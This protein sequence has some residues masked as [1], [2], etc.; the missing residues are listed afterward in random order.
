MSK[1]NTQKSSSKKRTQK[2]NKKKQKNQVTTTTP[3]TA[4]I[5]QHRNSIKFS[6]QRL[7]LNPFSTWMTLAV[8]A[9]ALALPTGLH[10]LLK[11]LSSVASNDGE[12]RASTISLF[13]KPSVTAQR[14]LDRSELLSER[15]EISSAKLI[16][17][18]QAIEN[19]KHIQGFKEILATIGGNPLPH[20]IAISPNLSVIAESGQTI[21]GFAKSLK[22]ESDVDNVQIDLEWVQRLR[23]ILNIA[24]RVTL[25]IATLLG[26]TVLLVVGNTIRLNI[27]GKKREIEIIQLIGATNHYIRRPFLY[28]GVW[29]GFFGGI[30]SLVIVH[31]SLLFIVAPVE[32]L[33][34]LY[35]SEFVISGVGIV[36]M[37]KL[38]F[39][40]ALLGLAGAWIAV[41]RHLQQQSKRMNR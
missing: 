40:S 36:I 8:I 30:L 17:K 29:Y 39:S 27:S 15:S 9:L 13:L 6:S 32:T 28:E 35:D 25:V 37:L 14:A 2:T 12:N 22:N 3:L 11:N 24:E 10:I 7:W 23:A 34:K 21:E 4:W 16:T 1:K 19:F 26:I 41:G 18:D 20:V 38:L 31:F 33:A 5:N